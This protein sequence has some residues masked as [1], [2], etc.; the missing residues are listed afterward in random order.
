[1]GESSIKYLLS[2]APGP[3]LKKL[4]LAGRLKQAKARRPGPDPKITWIWQQV[5]Q[6]HEVFSTDGDAGNDLLPL[7]GFEDN[8]PNKPCYLSPIQPLYDL[9]TLEPNDEKGDDALVL[10]PIVTHH[11]WNPQGNIAR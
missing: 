4:Q 9:F 1:V 6:S 8:R 2:P 3:D 5:D 11:V 7:L 10:C